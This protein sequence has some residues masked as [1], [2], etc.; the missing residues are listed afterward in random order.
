MKKDAGDGRPSGSGA[1]RKPPGRRTHAGAIY[2]VVGSSGLVSGGRLDH[3][4]MAV[5]QNVLGSLVVDVG[6][7]R[8]DA[9]FLRA[10]GATGDSFSIVKPRVGFSVPAPPGPF[11]ATARPNG[12]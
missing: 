1:Y 9:V 10:T 11:P 6:G 3:P 7:E 5:S 12:S 2:A 4:A 8:L